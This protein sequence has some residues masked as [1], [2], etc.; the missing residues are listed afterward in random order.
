ME[1]ATKATAASCSDSKTY[2][3]AK[4]LVFDFGVHV[5]VSYFDYRNYQHFS[6]TPRWFLYDVPAIVR[7][8]I[9]L[10]RARHCASFQF[11]SMVPDGRGCAIL[12]AA[13]APQYAK[14]SL[15]EIRA[16]LKN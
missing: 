1:R 10:A 5:G 16:N 7:A 4:S 12:L 15:P 11:T 2:W 3:S 14:E 8:G 13:S 6:K 9:Q